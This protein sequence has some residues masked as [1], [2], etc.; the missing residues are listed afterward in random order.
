MNYQT[1]KQQNPALKEV[2]FKEYLLLCE[3]TEIRYAFLIEYLNRSEYIGC[4]HLCQEWLND[5]QKQYNEK[6][7]AN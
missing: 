7:I 4:Q 2:R 5:V 6:G 3:G 1:A